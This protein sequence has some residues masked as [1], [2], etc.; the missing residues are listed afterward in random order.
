MAND[1]LYLIDPGFEVADRSDGPFVCPFCNQV[2]GLL[3][4]FPQLALDIEVV[5]VPFQRPRSAVIAVVGE[6]NQALPL[7]VLGDAPPSDAKSHGEVRFVADTDRILEL[8]A[9]RHGLPRLFRPAQTQ[10]SKVA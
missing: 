7:L 9:E 4:S 6:A 3:A 1:T 10:T 2:E 8:L 5:R